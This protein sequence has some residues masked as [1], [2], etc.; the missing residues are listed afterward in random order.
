VRARN[1]E[2][3]AAQLAGIGFRRAVEMEPEL[4]VGTGVMSAWVKARKVEGFVLHGA[5]W[6]READARR[7]AEEGRGRQAVAQR[8]AETRIAKRMARG[9]AADAT[10]DR[11]G[12]M[13]RT[14]LRAML[15]DVVKEVLS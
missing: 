3:A 15:V 12:D 5:V 7:H 14:E 4:G 8:A 1:G 11:V 13:T 10:R 6:V 2:A 9:A